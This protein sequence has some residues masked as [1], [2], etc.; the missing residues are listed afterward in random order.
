MRTILLSIL[1]IQFSDGKLFS[2]LVLSKE[3]L[4][5][6]QEGKKYIIFIYKLYLEIYFYKKKIRS[7]FSCSLFCG[8]KWKP[9]GCQVNKITAPLPFCNA[10]EFLSGATMSAPGSTI[11][12][13]V[14][15]PVEVDPP[16]NYTKG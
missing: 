16:I 11:R 6:I 5:A 14:I 7:S 2:N 9:N 13:M 10:T 8:M 4:N 3:D 15:D 12:S 1:M